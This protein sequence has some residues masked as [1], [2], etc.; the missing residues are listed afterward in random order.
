MGK[1]GRDNGRSRLEEGR[2]QRDLRVLSLLAA[3]DQRDCG[4]AVAMDSVALGGGTRQQQSRRAAR[5]ASRR[6]AGPA[7]PR[8]GRCRRR[9]YA[10]GP[11]PIP[12][13]PRPATSDRPPARGCAAAVADPTRSSHSSPTGR[14]REATTRFPA[15][16]PASPIASPPARARA[17]SAAPSASFPAPNFSRNTTSAL[18]TVP[19]AT[20][21]PPPRA[22]LDAA[23]SAAS[24]ASSC[25]SCGVSVGSSVMI[26]GLVYTYRRARDT[27]DPSGRR[28]GRR[29]RSPRGSAAVAGG[30]TW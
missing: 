18:R 21:G 14:G 6:P 17:T 29:G 13:S 15:P 23:G 26:V 5:G 25:A 27:G 4:R 8:S 9:G 19:A 2:K 28:P 7:V 22:A 24:A 10:T 20:P 11:G 16:S 1:K 3:R 12:G 30:A